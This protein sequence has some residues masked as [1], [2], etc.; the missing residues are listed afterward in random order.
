LDD[1]FA[2]DFA[3]AAGLRYDARTHDTLEMVNNSFAVYTTAVCYEHDVARFSSGTVGTAL[4]DALHAVQTASYEEFGLCTVADYAS[5]VFMY[6][7]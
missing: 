6:F 7:S 2:V 4:I 5:F 1:V 3:L